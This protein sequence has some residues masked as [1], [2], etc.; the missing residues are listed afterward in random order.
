MLLPSSSCY[1]CGPVAGT[2]VM[3]SVWQVELD[4]YHLLKQQKGEN[5]E[6]T[7]HAFSLEEH[8]CPPSQIR[9]Q[10]RLTDLVTGTGTGLL[11]LKKCVFE[12]LLCLL[13]YFSPIYNTAPLQSCFPNHG[14]FCHRCGSHHCFIAGQR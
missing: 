8:L 1:G 10:Y 6:I 12:C 9:K 5:E 7:R 2:V 11:A 13:P 14:Q 3:A 4:H